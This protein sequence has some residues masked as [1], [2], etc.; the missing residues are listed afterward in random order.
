[1]ECD[2]CEDTGPGTGNASVGVLTDCLKFGYKVAIKF[3]IELPF[4]LP[5]ENCMVIPLVEGGL[6][7]LTVK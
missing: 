5:K 2:G 7:G 6:N 3:D 4:D 1:M